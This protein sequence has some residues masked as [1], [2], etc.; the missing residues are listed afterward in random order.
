MTHQTYYF[1]A[2]DR[3]TLLDGFLQTAQ[4]EGVDPSALVTQDADG[5]YQ[6]DTSIGLFLDAGEWW[7]TEPTDSTAGTLGT[8]AIA[9]I[10]TDDPELQ[11]FL[12]TIAVGETRN[13][14]ERV[15]PATPVRSFV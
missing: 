11:S 14:V 3:Q 9:N 4:E 10:R 5:E 1:R 8:E 12:E 13:G 2:T 6:I 7:E 15:D